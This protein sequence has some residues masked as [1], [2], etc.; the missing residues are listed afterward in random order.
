MGRGIG[1]A[2]ALGLVLGLA[3]ALMAVRSWAIPAGRG[4]LGTDLIVA[5]APTGELAVSVTGPFLTGTGMHPGTEANGPSGRIGVYNRTAAVLDIRI[6]ARPS[7]PDLN[8]LLWMEVDAGSDRVY[9]GPLAG[10]VDGSPGSFR[11]A[12]TEDVTLSIRTWLPMSVET[13]YQGRVVTVDLTFV[14]TPVEVSR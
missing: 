2:R 12:P 5:T 13:G 10:L 9:R 8:H 7:R 3:I 4:E 14:P 11:L 1:A 6:Q